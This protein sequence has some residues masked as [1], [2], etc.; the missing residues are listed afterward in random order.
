MNTVEELVN[1]YGIHESTGQKMIE[2][3][4]GRIGSENVDFRITDITYKGFQTRDIEIDADCKRQRELT[5]LG[6]DVVRFSGSEINS[7]CEQCVNE[8]IRIIESRVCK[9]E[10]ARASNY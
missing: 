8:L 4:S 7:D 9:N 3:Y 10:S 5:L 6:Y 2:D 1:V